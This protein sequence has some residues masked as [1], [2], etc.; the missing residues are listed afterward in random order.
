MA[1]LVPFIPYIAA[2]FSVIGTISAMRAAEKQGEAA[3]QAGQF[4]AA[5]ATRNSQVAVDQSNMDAERQR[6]ETA[7]RQGVIRAGYGASGI[8]VEGSPLDIL[9]SSAALGELDR[10]TILYKGKLRAQGYT[11]T[12]TLDVMGGENAQTQAGYKAGNELFNGGARAYNAY[13]SLRPA[14]ASGT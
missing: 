10:Q 9:E 13:T 11:D 14:A 12:A 2:A 4:N 7:Q 6:R 5:V 8:T 3:E 1:F